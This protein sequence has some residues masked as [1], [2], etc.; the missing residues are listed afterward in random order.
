MDGGGS[1]RLSGA[2]IHGFHT[3]KDLDFPNMMEE[4][5]SRWLR[6]NEIY[7][8]LCN[9]KYFTIN[10]KPVN[11]PKSGTIVF[12]DRKML[13]NF[14]KD[15]HNWKKKKDGKTVKEAHEHLKIGNEERIHV[16]YAH[17]QDNP[18]FVR[19]CYWLLDK[20]LEHIVLVHYRET[21][22][23]QGSPATPVNSN[24]SSN[25]DQST[26]L[27][28]TKEFDSGAG[29]AYYEE[30]SDSVKVRNHAM[31]LHEINTLEWDELVVTND[32]NDSAVSRR[33]K[34]SCFDQGNQITVNGFSNDG[35][36]IS[37]YNLST[38]ISLL[39]N[40][41]GSVAQSNNAYLN[42]PDAVCYQISGVQ[43][44][45]NV[46]KDSSAIGTGES[47]DLLVNDSLQSQDSF[48]RW[49]D[50]VM[51]ESPGSRDDPVL[52][53]SISSCQDSF[54][55]QE[56]IFTITE[57]S[58]A[59]A[60]STEKT[61]ILVTGVFHQAYQHL[62]KSNLFCVCGDVCNPAEIIQV[63]VYRC[64]LSQHAPGLVNLY[65]SL[66]GHKPISQVSSFEYRAPSLHDPIV[67][68]EDES[69]WEE[70]LL[71]LRLAYLLFST[72]K[73]LNILS[74]KVSPNSLKE[75]KKFA[76]K[77]TNISNSW[78]YLIK[79]IE[80]NRASFTQAKDSLFEIAL[81]NRLK[82]WLLERIIEGSKT[83]EYDTQGQGVLHLCAILGY[84]W[85]IHL[86]SWSGLSLDFRDKQGWTALH[87]AA[88]YGREKMV[89][90]LLSA[91]AKPN[92]VTD[93]TTQNP[94]GCTAADL[95]SL[96]GYDG[97]AAYLSEEAL[98]AQF[99]DM[100]VAGNAFGSLQT[101]KTEATNCD[102]LDEDELYLRETLAAYRTTADAAAR[103]HT[104]F[105]QHSFKIR[106]KAVES[107]NPEYE[108]RNI[109]AALKI[110]HAFRNY[111]TKKKMAA[112]A[113]IQYRF[114]TWKMHKNFV[115]MRRQ[116]IKIQ[117][118]FRG[119]QVR[120]QY[121][122]IL[123]S[124]GVLEKAILRWRLKKKGF[125]GLQ[126]NTVEAVAEQRQESDTEEDFYKTS[127]KQAEE[128]VE[129]AV[130]RVQSMFRSRRAQEEYLRMKKTRDLAALEYESLLSPPS[131]MD[132]RRH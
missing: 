129:K 97:I 93:P 69:R 112:A 12:F 52:E 113:S 109:V 33:D 84:A 19:R 45:S 61:K 118:A 75:A 1:S 42:T 96:K 108:A 23:L 40:L 126:V 85:A 13:R 35:D 104:A 123:W 55:S 92:L 47:L 60:Y 56:Q 51:T 72:S 14:R 8:V 89:A 122:K 100:A 79:S 77:T 64:L 7:A 21:Q 107:S 32:C 88:Y 62:V 120:R 24:S 38:E 66:D 34:N 121:R 41:V 81:K 68:L 25:S 29:N 91:G 74:G 59:W 36:P 111:E 30:P 110:Q 44:N 39:G 3:L 48:G 58:P 87:W 73:S 101:S 105:R 82:D 115:N 70:F 26:S 16:Y 130:V 4:A 53:S 15:G 106:A 117:A 67:P 83:T 54:T 20:T 43:V 18:T 98:V 63:G 99:N 57:V 27:L 71:Q 86:F 2:E 65:M 22:E 90:V 95:A 49:M 17:G 28:V 114:R 103:I 50:R 78:T 128:R 80:E 124:V 132:A 131:D 11:L 102:N 127:R 94:S 46:Q 116:A 37:A 31:T 6:P 10:A 5:R 125:R 9:H 76:Q 119:F